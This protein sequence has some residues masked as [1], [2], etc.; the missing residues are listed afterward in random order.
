MIGS[1]SALDPDWIRTDRLPGDRPVVAAVSV[2]TDV[3]FPVGS[4]IKPA[5]PATAA[6]LR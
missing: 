2:A 1:P 4:E 6:V 5:A 3:Q